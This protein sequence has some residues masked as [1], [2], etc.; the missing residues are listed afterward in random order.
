MFKFC[1]LN[2]GICPK[3]NNQL[4]DDSCFV[5]DAK[6][7]TISL[8][9]IKNS[10]F[11]RKI[12]KYDLKGNLID[13]KD[14]VYDYYPLD[15]KNEQYKRAQ[16]IDVC[17]GKTKKFEGFQWRYAD[18]NNEVD[19][20]NS[21]VASKKVIQVNFEGDIINEFS[22]VNE[23]KK[24]IKKSIGTISKCCK[25][26]IPPQDTDYFLFFK[27]Y[28]CKNV[29]LEAYKRYLKKQF[30]IHVKDDKG[31]L[32]GKYDSYV[33]AANELGVSATSVSSWC[34]GVFRPSGKYEN[35][36]FESYGDILLDKK[37]IEK[38]NKPGKDNCKIYIDNT[39]LSRY[40][41]FL[42][43]RLNNLEIENNELRLQIEDLIMK[44]ENLE[45]QYYIRKPKF[46]TRVS[47]MKPINDFLT[48][49]LYNILAGVCI[50][51]LCDINGN[52]YVGQSSA[53]NYFRIKQHFMDT[54][55]N[56][57]NAW[58]SGIDFF[59]ERIIIGWGNCMPFNLDDAETYF[60]S[61]YDSYKNGY[62]RNGGNHQEFKG[63]FDKEFL[64]DYI[65][66]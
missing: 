2:I 16:V 45:R 11:T 21:N 28:Y 36:I 35:Y 24:Q 48:E 14:N 46:E 56:I 59:V 1:T 33:K 12:K 41:S 53:N 6:V 31:N 29:F 9:K 22:S 7:R 50:Y 23:A 61:Y 66:L 63:R 32:I 65:Y 15:E 43:E 20:L 42:T 57:Y 4:T 19:N 52:R 27:D 25:E 39:K 18:D 47:F 3:C 10:N 37:I 44:N 17:E 13:I 51:V 54:N 64:N 60:I 5:C 58:K 62:N 40:N 38:C 34:R 26:H 30:I 8:K 55:D 49:K